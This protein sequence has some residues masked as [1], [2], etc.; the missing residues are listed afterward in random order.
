MSKF[1]NN[2]RKRGS[3]LQSN[4]HEALGANDAKQLPHFDL[5]FCFI[6]YQEKMK[7]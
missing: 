1:S 7:V 6:F 3:A 5:I 4:K 2:E